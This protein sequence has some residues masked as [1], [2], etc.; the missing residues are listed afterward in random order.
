M[1][2]VRL[3][4]AKKMDYRVKPAMTEERLG[5]CVAVAWQP[6]DALAIAPHVLIPRL[7]LQV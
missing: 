6:S 4:F 1:R 2:F 5:S 3:R 7:R